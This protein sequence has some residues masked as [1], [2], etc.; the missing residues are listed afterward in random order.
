MVSSLPI[1]F[2]RVCTHAPT[3]Y[4]S[5]TLS[6]LEDIIIG[7]QDLDRADLLRSQVKSRFEFIA[8]INAHRVTRFVYS[9]APQ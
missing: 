7:G 4:Q 9:M 5:F 2:G 3:G 1:A 8:Q 6:G